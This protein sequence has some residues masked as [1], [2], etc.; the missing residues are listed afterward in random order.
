MQ[1]IEQ[2]LEA[3]NIQITAMRLLVYRFLADQSVAVTL[4]DMEQAFSKEPLFLEP[5]KPLKKRESFTK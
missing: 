3:K 5:S 4:S 2:F 1:T